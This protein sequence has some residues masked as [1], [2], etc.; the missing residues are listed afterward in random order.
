MALGR[1]DTN[2]YDALRLKL[3]PGANIQ[4]ARNIGYHPAVLAWAKRYGGIGKVD[5]LLIL[6]LARQSRLFELHR[7]EPLTTPWRR[8]IIPTKLRSER[9]PSEIGSMP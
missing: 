5:R 9:A 3:K 2:V 8:D 1:I 6:Q 7:S 4:E